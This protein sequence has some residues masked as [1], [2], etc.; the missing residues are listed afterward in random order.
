MS[1]VPASRSINHQGI[2]Q[3]HKLGSTP[4]PIPFHVRGANGAA[5]GREGE[6]WE[7]DPFFF[8]SKGGVKF[9]GTGVMPE[10]AQGPHVKNP[11]GRVWRELKPL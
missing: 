8:V 1:P 7:K 3:P 5:P 2:C 6:V 4:L 11:L 9:L 10:R